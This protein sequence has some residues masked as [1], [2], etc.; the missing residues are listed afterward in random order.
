MGTCYHEKITN[1]ANNPDVDKDML[2][3]RCE[4]IARLL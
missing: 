4:Q 3:H 2:S 1:L